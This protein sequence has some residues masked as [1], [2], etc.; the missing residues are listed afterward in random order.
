M[1]CLLLSASVYA[2]NLNL[3]AP[4]KVYEVKLSGGLSKSIEFISEDGLV[5]CTYQGNGY[6]VCDL[7]SGR[8]LSDEW[9]IRTSHKPPM[10]LTDSQIAYVPGYKAQAR[11]WATSR[12]RPRALLDANRWVAL[13]IEGEWLTI[14]IIKPTERGQNP[15]DVGHLRHN[16]TPSDTKAAVGPSFVRAEQRRVLVSI[17]RRKGSAIV[18]SEFAK[19]HNKNSISKMRYWSV[20]AKPKDFVVD[21]DHETRQVLFHFNDEWALATPGKREP[22]KIGQHA[23]L[24]RGKLM[25]TRG[26]DLWMRVGSLWKRI[27]PFKLLGTNSSECMALFQNFETGKTVA[28]TF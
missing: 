4:K 15:N 24:F 17:L 11:T 20:P 12:T 8:E 13:A 25:E 23:Y 26:K 1:L 21:F 6:S 7:S 10:L 14:A 5:A 3:L 16:V 2:N 18:I 9:L 19:E 22:L 27:G 28:L